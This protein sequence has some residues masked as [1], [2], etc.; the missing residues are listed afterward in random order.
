[1]R[2]NYALH[3]FVMPIFLHGD[4]GHLCSNIIAQL[5]I[6]SN[7]EPDIGV[8]KFLTLYMLSGIGGVTFSAMCTDT[9]SV[10]ASTAVFGLS[11]AY[12]AFIILNYHYLSSRPDKLCQVILFLLISILL[13]VLLGAKNIDVLGHLGGFITGAICGHWLLPC[14]ET[15]MAK[16]SRARTISTFA[17]VL[18]VIWFVTMLSVFYLAREPVDKMLGSGGVTVSDSAL[19]GAEKSEAA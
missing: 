14:L 18:T 19:S 5:M 16:L 8:R 3:R 4:L 2:Y 6:G 7:L 17:K 13:S 9:L 10:G 11:G 1:M 12:V 15:D